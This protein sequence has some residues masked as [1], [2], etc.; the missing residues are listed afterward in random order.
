MSGHATAALAQ[1]KQV[2]E[3]AQ[4]E[5]SKPI[6]TGT[7][8]RGLAL[9]LRGLRKSFGDN[10]VLRGV[11]LHILAGQF[12]AI[13][14]RSGCGKSTLL[15]LIAGLDTYDSGTLAFEEG[16]D[17]VQPNVRVMFQVLR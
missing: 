3:R 10:K 12:V 4:A 2:F 1:P 6:T 15:R 14:G 8:P 11:D 9:T 5:L 7:S 13:V 17:N 16:A